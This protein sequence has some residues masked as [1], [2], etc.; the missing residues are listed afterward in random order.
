MDVNNAL[1]AIRAELFEP[2]SPLRWERLMWWVVRHAVADPDANA[3]VVV[4]YVEAHALERWPPYPIQGALASALAEFLPDAAP[5]WLR[6]VRE[7]ELYAHTS[8]LTP[9][10]EASLSGGGVLRAG[11]FEALV[12]SPHAQHLARLDVRAPLGAAQLS[13][14]ASSPH[15]SRLIR[16]DL[17]SCSLDD[18]ALAALSASTHLTALRALHLNNNALTL[19]G[20]ET[21]ARSPLVR[22]LEVLSVASNRDITAR[23]RRPNA[24]RTALLEEL[25]GRLGAGFVM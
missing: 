3:N 9:D 24:R 16:L 1:S 15:M 10:R 7:L 8:P 12:G 17:G 11:W 21:F 6:L 25:R 18:A 5:A 19:E 2:P 14:L 13:A 4:P 22:R 23:R 20:M